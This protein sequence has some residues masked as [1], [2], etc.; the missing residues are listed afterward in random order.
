M[1]GMV[2]TV[3]STPMNTGNKMP[4]ESNKL[5]L[6]AED[7]VRMMITQLQQQDP[8]E[9]AKNDQLLAQMSQISQLQSSTALQE[10]LTTVVQQN[11][12]GA[13]AGL[14]GK[15]V[16]GMAADNTTIS[17]QVTAVRVEGN[18]VNLELDNGK[19]LALSRVTTIAPQPATPAN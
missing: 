12:I 8:M 4:T 11:Q 17:G 13:A 3:Q 5:K 6:K 10:S 16:Q 1:S 14:I 7:F 9:P 18:S 2:N 19:S 15:S